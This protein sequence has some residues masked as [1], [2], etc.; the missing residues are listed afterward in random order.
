MTQLPGRYMSEKSQKHNEPLIVFFLKLSL[1]AIICAV[2]VY[3]ISLSLSNILGLEKTSVTAHALHSERHVQISTNIVINQPGM[4]KDWPAYTP[5]RLVVPA[6]SLVT[7]TLRNYDLG[8]TSMP[9]G[10]PFTTIRGVVH[11]VAYADGKAYSSLPPQ[12]IAHTFTISQMNINVPVPGDT[13]T[14][15]SYV[16]VSFSFH[17]GAAGSYSFQ[18]FDPC[19]TGSVGWQGPMMSKGYMMGTLTVQ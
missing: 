3:G 5:T 8:D 19:G 4:K 10:S 12:K 13:K 7:L 6:Y 2:I 11:G 14:G 16:E 17:T 9:K 1:S 15:K 18:C